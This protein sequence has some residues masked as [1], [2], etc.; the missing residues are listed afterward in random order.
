MK[1]LVENPNTTDQPIE[2]TRLE[3]S[4]V[5][6][7]G[8]AVCHGAGYVV[9]AQKTDRGQIRADGRPVIC[10]CVAKHFVGRKDIREYDG[11]M[12]WMPRTEYVACGFRWTN[13]TGDRRRCLLPPHAVST[14]HL[15]ESGARVAHPRTAPEPA[16]DTGKA[17]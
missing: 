4:R 15:D 10:R 9:F 8:C 5:A 13:D 12:H 3:V 14:A 6:K 1:H 7:T 16:P 17:A 2:V 11:K